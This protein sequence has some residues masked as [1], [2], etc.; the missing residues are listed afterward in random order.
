MTTYEQKINALDTT[1]TAIQH[2]YENS[3]PV[4][5]KD[6]QNA[7]RLASKKI[8]DHN[9]PALKEF[10]QAAKA[11]HAPEVVADIKQAAILMLECFLVTAENLLA[12]KQEA[13]N[14]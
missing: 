1:I 2:K 6:I 10:I 4:A 8:S 12:A 14:A 9:S 11:K 5:Y 3:N 7:L 13:T